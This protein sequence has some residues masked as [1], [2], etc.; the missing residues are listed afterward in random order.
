M[1]VL[2][3]GGVFYDICIMQKY[4]IFIIQVHMPK[5]GEFSVWSLL[6]GLIL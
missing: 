5:R 3:S 2:V 6:P 1:L 4:T